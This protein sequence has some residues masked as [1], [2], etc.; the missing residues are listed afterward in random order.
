[1]KTLLKLLKNQAGAGVATSLLAFAALGVGVYY[2]LENSVE[3]NKLLIDMNQNSIVENTMLDIKTILA[4]ADQCKLAM[5][6]PLGAFQK[7]GNY[8]PDLNNDIGLQV[9]VKG[10]ELANSLNGGREQEYRVR[11]LKKNVNKGTQQEKTDTFFIQKFQSTTETLCSSFETAGVDNSFSSFCS[12]LGGH[13][14]DTTGRCDTSNINSGFF[15]GTLGRLACAVLGAGGTT[16]CNGVNIPLGTLSTNY[17]KNNL[18]SLGLGG[19]ISN[20]AGKICTGTQVASG[21]NAS[22]G[23]DCKGIICPKP[24]FSSYS[25]NLSGTKIMCQCSRD[26]GPALNCGAKDVTSCTAYPVDDGCGTGRTCTIKRGKYPPC[27]TIPGCGNEVFTNSCG[28][29]CGSQPACP[30]RYAYAY[31]QNFSGGSQKCYAVSPDCSTNRLSKNSDNEECSRNFSNMFQ[32]RAVGGV[33]YLGIQTVEGMQATTGCTSF[34]NARPTNNFFRI[35][36]K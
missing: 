34:P 21:F 18:L 5:E 6:G 7:I 19:N 24:D 33:E 27:P 1:M 13:F 25:P 28:E 26:R 8:T 35:E 10:I 23:V 3:R 2:V 17:F 36:V 9:F 11:F 29:R 31:R 15:S 32:M 16:Q 22:G 20:F 4:N 30:K 14:D 12:A